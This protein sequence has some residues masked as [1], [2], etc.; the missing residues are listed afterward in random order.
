MRR[1][2][3]APKQKTSSKARRFALT[4]KKI[5]RLN[6]HMSFDKE[7]LR[8]TAEKSLAQGKIQAAI[9]DYCRIAENDPR[10][11]NT[12]NTLGD[13][14][15]RVNAPE[16]AVE[17]FTRIAEYYET[18]GF[19]HK[20]I[21]MY[22]K[23]ARLKPD[24]IKVSRRLA[25]LY[26]T[27]G[28]VAEARSHFLAV[29]DFYQQK[30]DRLPALEIWQQI[31]DLD[32]NDVKTRLNLAEN[33]AKE[34][35]IEKAVESY[36]EAGTRLLAKKRVEE[37]LAAFNE[38]L[39][40]LPSDLKALSGVTEAHIALGFPDE[41]V[42]KLEYARGELASEPEFHALL[43]KCYIELE[44]PHLAEQAVVSL[45]EKDPNSFH[46]LLDLTRLYV[47]VNDLTSAI[48]TVELSSESL[49][50]NGQENEL[51]F[52]LN[53]ILT[54]DP[55]HLKALRM[56][57][58]LRSWQ[59]NELAL[60]EVLE[61]LVE[62]A[63]LGEA[64]DE[65]RDALSELRMLFPRE[66]QY[67]ERLQELGVEIAPEI[68]VAETRSADENLIPSFESFAT[69]ADEN[70]AFQPFPTDDDFGT[71]P[72]EFA[73]SFEYENESEAPPIVFNYEV[74]DENAF[75][76]QTDFA[77][78]FAAPDA[79][80]EIA[81]LDDAPSS[82]TEIQ[83]KSE[84]ESV[85]F[86]LSQGYN[87]LALENLLLLEK[88]YGAHDEISARIEQIQSPEQIEK[89]D[90]FETATAFAEQRTEDVRREE[91]TAEPLVTEPVTDTAANGNG[92]KTN[93][94]FADLF[95]DFDEGEQ[96]AGEIP[97]NHIADYET[98]YN[99]GLAYKEMGLFD[100][101]VEEFQTAVKMV[102]PGDGTP[103][104][105]QC[106]NLIGH[107]FVEKGMP[108]LAIKWYERGLEAPGHTEE[109]Y[110]ALRYELGTAFEKSGE[111]DKAIAQFTEVYAVNVA[112]R[113]VGEKL[114]TLQAI[115]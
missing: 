29:A 20:A 35:Q 24:D 66:T 109:E 112:Y 88:Q 11:Y 13:L 101:A 86:Y 73:E 47:K 50:T 32:P 99:L 106:C 18:Q 15:A 110:N 31:A 59:R 111:T 84:L 30:G 105:L 114:R 89:L 45:I 56:L 9:K 61:R 49:L 12:L 87:D 25:P 95:D 80:S 37:A 76:Q 68:S 21:A 4:Q 78:E 72:E 67:S 33:Y 107:C 60:K 70:Y 79:E 6:V 92:N 27:L 104:F 39:R 71:D 48:R 63:R 64:A 26:Q 113:S 97:D 102:A 62:A 7:K 81:V 1:Q 51:E 17:C 74:S 75:E 98:H 100:D 22:K 3:I 53:E 57:A 54:R 34:K 14:Y 43:A 93:P 108:H 85:D 94:N 5:P 46:R 58:R 83:L 55:E 36:T 96:F 23:I 82:N 10:D 28:L 44:H 2:R 90:Q 115:H 91:K 41:A 69:F 103:R 42:E 77:F 38:A 40:L 16:R 19:S 52:W 65:E 8:R